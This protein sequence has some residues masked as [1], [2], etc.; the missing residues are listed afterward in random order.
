[1]KLEAT[2]LNEKSQSQKDKHCVIPL[3][4]GIWSSQMYRDRKQNGRNGELLI[5]GWFQFRK[6]K[7]WRW[8]EVTVVQQGDCVNT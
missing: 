6:M 7:L 4:R 2:M 3:I 5:H 1:M 8:M